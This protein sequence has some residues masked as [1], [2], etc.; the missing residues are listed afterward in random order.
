MRTLIRR[1]FA[2]A[3][4]G[5]ACHA[6]V[7][8]QTAHVQVVFV[9]G[10]LNTFE[11]AQLSTSEAQKALNGLETRSGAQGRHFV[12]T[13]IYNPTGWDV[14][15]LNPEVSASN[16]LHDLL[17]LFMLKTA[18]ECFRDDFLS[19]SVPHNQS[20]PIDNIDAAV[21]V[22]RFVDNL[23]P[24]DAT[25]GSCGGTVLRT[26]GVVTPADMEV[27]R[28]TVH[29]LTQKI[30]SF[31][32]AIVVAHSQGNLLA[33]LAYASLVA[34]YGN[35]V[36]SKIRIVNVANTSSL[37]ANGLDLT[38]TGD[39]AIKAL[40]TLPWSLDLVPF[41][42]QRTTPACS[43]NEICPFAASPPSLDNADVDVG[44][45]FI[46]TYLSD[47]PV[48]VLRPQG[49][50]LTN[51]AGSYKE[52]FVDF[53]YAAAA[54]LDAHAKAAPTIPV[55]GQPVSATVSAGQVAT[56]VVQ[57]NGT[58][59]LTYQWRKNGVPVS[60]AT[61]SA[62]PRYVT[63]PTTL[64][65]SGAIYDVVVSNALGSVTSSS[66][67]LAVT[68]APS[69]TPDLALDMATFS[70]DSLAPGGT[71]RVSF[72]V[73]N[74]GSAAASPSTAVLR[75]NQSTTSAAGSN[76][77]T[78]SVPAVPAGGSVALP[79]VS[80]PAPSSPGVYRL[81]IVLDND[82]TSGQPSSAEG[83][84]LSLVYGTLV[85]T[86]PTTGGADLVAL[87]LAFN[88]T[89]VSAGGM[90]LASFSITNVGD[91]ASRASGAAVRIT[92]ST[93]SPEGSPDLNFVSVPALAPGEGKTFTVAVNVPQAVGTYRYWVVADSTRS[94]GQ[95]AGKTDN[96]AAVATETVAVG[97]RFA[98]PSGSAEGAYEGSL[99]GS[100]YPGF[101]TWVLENGEFW[102]LYG[103]NAS[104][105]F[106]AYG[107]VH[108]TATSANGQLVASSVKD[109]GY[110]PAAQ[111][112]LTSAYNLGNGTI[113]GTFSFPVGI[114][115]FNAAPV[116]SV[117]YEYNRPAALTDVVG[118][119]GL[120]SNTGD[121]LSVRISSTGAISATTRLG[122]SFTGTMQPSASGKNVF[123][124]NIH[125]GSAPCLLP[126]QTLQGIA[127]THKLPS[128]RSQLNV[129]AINQAGNAGLVA[130][131]AR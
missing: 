120:A 119:W 125:F 101:R 13:S 97:S 76:L 72:A 28:R 24:S 19:I 10:I 3:L 32:S 1:S 128:G 117:P 42:G 18:E 112:S 67:A 71:V 54:S 66:A 95:A 7:T 2:A 50:A 83:N 121:T 48:D 84:D 63:P 116:T 110:Y 38:H 57:P 53:V 82:R 60:C 129:A 118:D 79:T 92:Q 105:Y 64:A 65:D 36:N 104:D 59:P 41:A 98:S 113:S 31:G 74:H 6:G 52:R 123:T 47:A 8:A 69:R 99:T 80:L 33:N 55:L 103:Q 70:P 122:C 44:H 75:F 49:V 29:A 11:D 45:S 26:S 100:S 56:F 106:M 35:D 89:Q 78:V 86:G 108:G 39:S 27:T 14:S 77:A 124:G 115:S 22:K 51:I 46:G 94:A 73:A 62:C 102:G 131:G 85:V 16:T 109:F 37:S 58:G 15:V 90:A 96:D 68:A 23:I 81:W 9:N 127:V 17:E 114:V 93:S 91:S 34:Q 21:R 30:Q 40:I 87:N 111:G 107:F 88:P 4:I 126:G 61:G 12:V 25:S 20:R 130:S 5:L 43:L